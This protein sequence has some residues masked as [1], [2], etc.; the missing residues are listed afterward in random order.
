VKRSAL[1]DIAAGISFGGS[2]LAAVVSGSDG[3][4]WECA[5]FTLAAALGAAIVWTLRP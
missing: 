2:A 4:A 1:L 3:R 5:L